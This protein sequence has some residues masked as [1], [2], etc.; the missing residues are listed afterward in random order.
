MLHIGLFLTSNVLGDLYIM[1]DFWCYLAFVMG[2]FTL[3]VGLA[4]LSSGLLIMC[5]LSTLLERHS[6]TQF[7]FLFYRVCMLLV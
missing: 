5:V 1:G 3:V 4:E 7:K 6:L 2:C